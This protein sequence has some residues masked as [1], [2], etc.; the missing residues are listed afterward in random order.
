MLLNDHTKLLKDYKD[1]SSANKNK[2]ACFNYIQMEDQKEELKQ[3][4]PSSLS[5]APGSGFKDMD[6]Q[7]HK[8]YNEFRRESMNKVQEMRE[9]HKRRQLAGVLG[10]GP[11]KNLEGKIEVGTGPTPV[12]VKRQRSNF[13]S[14]S[15]YF[16]SSKRDLSLKSP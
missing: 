10:F 14:Y 11:E 4:K 16:D 2:N 13:Q 8:N 7:M 9:I 12:P 1:R 15:S 5:R 3:R 6:G